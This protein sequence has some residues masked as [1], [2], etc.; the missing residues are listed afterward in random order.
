MD[1]ER[2]DL[3]LGMA[4]VR[5]AT[6]RRERNRDLVSGDEDRLAELTIPGPVL[7]LDA[8]ERRE[9]KLAAVD[10]GVD[11]GEGLA[12]VTGHGLANRPCRYVGLI[13]D[14]QDQALEVLL[15][16]VVHLGRAPLLVAWAPGGGDEAGRS[17]HRPRLAAAAVGHERTEQLVFI[18][19]DDDV[20]IGVGG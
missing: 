9:L 2:I 16:V 13:V 5:E 14:R 19:D 10:E 20:V 3:D 15:E 4:C 18:G 7:L 8:L 17:S 6:L 11:L 1:A 12:V